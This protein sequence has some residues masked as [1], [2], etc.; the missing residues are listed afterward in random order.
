MVRAGARLSCP[1]SGGVINAQRTIIGSGFMPLAH[2]LWAHV[3]LPFSFLGRLTEKEPL[4]RA[5]LLSLF[6]ACW[7]ALRHQAKRQNFRSATQVAASTAS[8]MVTRSGGMAS[9]FVLLISMLPRH[10]PR[11]ALMKRSSGA[12]RHSGF[13]SW[14]IK[15]RSKLGRLARV[16]RTNM[17]ESFACW[18]V[19]AVRSVTSLCEKGWRV[20]GTEPDIH[21][22]DMIA[23]GSCWFIH[24][25]TLVQ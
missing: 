5:R 1:S 25:R 17:G 24:G 2:S 9:K 18:F 19:A 7:A 16:T 10:I 20:H 13:F 15:G 14:S 12:R 11:V 8:S 3:D 23:A 21:G 4:R 6:R 22:A